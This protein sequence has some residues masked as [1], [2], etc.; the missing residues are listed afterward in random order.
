MEVLATTG[1]ESEFRIPFAGLAALL[2]PLLPRLPDLPPPR[3][4]ALAHALALEPASGDRFAVGVAALDLLSLVA[5]E[6]PTCAIVDDGHWLD[7]ASADALRF[8]ARRLTRDRVAILVAARDGEDVDF[9]MAGVPQLVLGGLEPEAGR[10]LLDQ[11][12]PEPLPAATA[13]TLVSATGGNPLALAEVTTLC[14]RERLTELETLELPVPV[15]P[16]LSRALSRRIRTLR[17][18]SQRAMSLAAVTESSDMAEIAAVLRRLNLDPSAL[19][20]AERAGLIEIDDGEVR[21]SHPLLRAVAYQALPAPE[22]RIAHLAVAETVGERG[23]RIRRAWHLASAVV[24]PDETVAGLL[25]SAARD[26]GPERLRQPPER[27]SGGRRTCR[28]RAAIASGD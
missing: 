25:E 21:F 26:P 12:L 8:A 27:R 17:F 9:E 7:P 24:E 18:R 14:D 28:R 19:T 15:G 11:L 4:A 2:R 10:T 13:R 1:V 3:R 23:P 6:T 22:R 20:D 5:E 16:E